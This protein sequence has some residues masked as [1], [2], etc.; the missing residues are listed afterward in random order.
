VVI[1][2]RET[3]EALLG[4]RLASSDLGADEKSYLTFLVDRFRYLDFRGMGVTERVPLKLPLLDLYVPL[5][6][7]LSYPKAKRGRG[8]SRLLAVS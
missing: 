2:D 4:K 8:T 3:V 7:A 5:Q 6:A 1:A